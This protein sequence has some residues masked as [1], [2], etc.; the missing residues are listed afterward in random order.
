MGES[1]NKITFGVK[2]LHIATFKTEGD[3]ITYDVPVKV[4]GT[5]QITLNAV[6]EEQ[7][8][9]ADDSIYYTISGSASYE[10]EIANFSISDDILMKVFGHKKDKNGAILETDDDKKKPVAIMWETSGDV[11]NKRMIL[12]NVQLKKPNETFSTKTENT[13]AEPKTMRFTATPRSTDHLLK[14][15]IGN[16]SENADQAK[17][18]KDFFTKVYEPEMIANV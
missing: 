16:T 9:Y 13:N 14:T 8:V 10:G 12:Y 4:L 15:I 3:V 6:G 1:E 11:K 2:N 18:Y 7:Q 5:T 17:A